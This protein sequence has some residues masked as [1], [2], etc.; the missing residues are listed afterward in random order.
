MNNLFYLENHYSLN[1]EQRKIIEIIESNVF[2]YFFNH[3]TTNKFHQF[4]HTLMDRDPLLRPITGSINSN[5]FE[6]CANMFLEICCQNNIKV[7]NILRAAI[8]CTYHYSENMGEIHLDHEGFDHYNFIM[9]LNDFN[10]GSTYIFDTD[11]TTLLK[12]CIA[13]KNKFVI[14]NGYPHAQGFCA[15]GQIRKVLVFTFN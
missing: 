9:Y 14:F 8:N 12:E 2:P 4:A 1:D 11:R 5:F 10:F 3:T 15:P 7:N 6:K 13:E